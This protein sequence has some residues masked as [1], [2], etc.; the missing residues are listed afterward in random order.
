MV[1]AKTF[2][3]TSRP[4]RNIKMLNTATKVDRGTWKKCSAT[5]PRPVVP[6][7]IS[8]LGKRNSVT[9]RAYRVLPASTIPSF[10]AP[11]MAFFFR[12]PVVLPINFPPLQ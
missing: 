3:S 1:R 8:P 11:R 9:P 2:P 4:T 10:H 7:V 6:P 12:L 5:S